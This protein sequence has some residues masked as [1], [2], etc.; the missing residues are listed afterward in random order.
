MTATVRNQIM[1]AALA[2][3]NNS[4]PGGVPQTDDGR[5]QPYS[6]DELPTAVLYEIREDD[7]NE[8]EGRWS[9]FLK[10]TFTMRI[11]VRVAAPAG[12]DSP[13]A[14][15]DPILVWIGKTL[16]AQQF[17]GLAEDCYEQHTEWQRADE[18]RPYTMV[19]VDFVIEYSTLKSD[20]TRTQ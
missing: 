3:L 7:Q 2:M 17:N 9:Y 12:G 6:E 18:S 20:P 16:G 10:R 5:I 8:K 15:I 19:Q 14:A 4:P 13:R 1:D 11:E